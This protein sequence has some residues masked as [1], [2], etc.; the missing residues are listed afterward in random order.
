[1]SRNMESY[2]P[3]CKRPWRSYSPRFRLGGRYSSERRIRV[4]AATGSVIRRSE[5]RVL[6]SLLSGIEN[7]GVQ[8]SGFGVRGSGSSMLRAP[9]S[10]LL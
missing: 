1:M 2:Y 9:R 7:R 3:F 10:L 4:A 5:R 6:R 8:G